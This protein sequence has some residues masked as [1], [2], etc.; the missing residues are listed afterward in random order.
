MIMITNPPGWLTLAA[1]RYIPENK[2]PDMPIP[3]MTGWIPIWTL[4]LPGDQPLVRLSIPEETTS[5]KTIVLADT[6]TTLF[7]DPA[8]E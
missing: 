2:L 7:P 8:C 5:R 4:H 3:G 6:M 1:P